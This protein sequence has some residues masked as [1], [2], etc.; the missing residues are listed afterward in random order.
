MSA[1]IVEL[2]TLA[3]AVILEVERAIVGKHSLLETVMAAVLATSRSMPPREWLIRS[4][5]GCW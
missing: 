1:E 4:I 3:Q 5:S 2:S